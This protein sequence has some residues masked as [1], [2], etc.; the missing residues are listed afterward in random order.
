[1]D[2]KKLFLL[3]LQRMEEALGRLDRYQAKIE[4]IETNFN[5]L[6]QGMENYHSAVL[7]RFEQME[8]Y[9]SHLE[10]EIEIL[11]RNVPGADEAL[12]LQ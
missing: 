5:K 2:E 7:Q 8:H 12:P 4:I 11:Q 3:L 6:D 1:M 9:I 10:H